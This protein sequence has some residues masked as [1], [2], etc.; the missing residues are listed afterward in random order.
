MRCG[1]DGNSVLQATGT[2]VQEQAT[3]PMM[4]ICYFDVKRLCDNDSDNNAQVTADILI[5]IDAWELG[6]TSHENM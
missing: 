5:V 6:R 4:N 3:W 2:Q 1:L